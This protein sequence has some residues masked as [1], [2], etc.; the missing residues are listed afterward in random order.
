MNSQRD[1]TRYHPPINYGSYTREPLYFEGR[2]RKANY[3]AVTLSF[4]IETIFFTTKNE[5][6]TSIPSES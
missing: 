1:K 2:I 3:S 6:K 4:I 5:L